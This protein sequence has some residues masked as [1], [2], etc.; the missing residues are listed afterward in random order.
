[1]RNRRGNADDYLLLIWG[2]F[3]ELNLRLMVTDASCAHS[4]QE[5]VAAPY[6]PS[7]HQTPMRNCAAI[8]CRAC[9]ARCSRRR[10]RSERSAPA[11]GGSSGQLRP[12][13]D[14]HLRRRRSPT[15]PHP[16]PPPPP[17][18]AAYE[19]VSERSDDSAGL[20]I[21]AARV[22]APEPPR[23]RG[24]QLIAHLGDPPPPAP[25]HPDA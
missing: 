20:V 11:W 23:C 16:A 21:S 25:P 2:V 22:A 9:P 1:M 17:T 6:L 15:W 4:Q 7:L 13:Q 24:G 5:D 12:L 18:S 8:S 10:D 19:K 14:A 3:V